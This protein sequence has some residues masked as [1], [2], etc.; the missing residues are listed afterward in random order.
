[1]VVNAPHI[2]LAQNYINTKF[3]VYKTS[4]SSISL[5]SAERVSRSRKIFQNEKAVK[6]GFLESATY[7]QPGRFD[8]SAIT[9]KSTDFPCNL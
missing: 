8:H 4:K 7:C 2:I 1:M 3:N 9:R 6:C 5:G